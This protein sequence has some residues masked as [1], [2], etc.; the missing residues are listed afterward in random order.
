MK[1]KQLT[2]IALLISF[3]LVSSIFIGISM[4]SNTV[5][6]R[7]NYRPSPTPTASSSGSV[8]F[9]NAF[10]N[11]FSG[12][13]TTGSVST[14]LNSAI[15]SNTIKAVGPESYW[16]KSLAGSYSDLFF[17]GYV[18]VASLPSN[19]QNTLLLK[20][21]DSSFA[22]IVAGG[23]QV[24]GGNSYW[25]L[26]TNGN[27]YTA[28]T[29]SNVQTNHWYF[30]EIEYNTAGTAKMWVDGSLLYTALGES[31]TN[32]PSILQGG[33][34]FSGTPAGF[35]S[36]ATGYTAATSFIVDPPLG[37]PSSP[38]PTPTATSTPSPTAT[39]QPTAT[40]TATPSPSPVPTATPSPTPKPSPTPTPTLAPTPTATPAPTPSP[41]PKPTATPSPTPTPTPAPSGSPLW[42]HTSGQN[43]YDSNGK[44]VKL[45]T[46]DIEYGGS[47]HITLSDIQKIKSMGFNAVR[48]HIY[49]QVLQPNGPTSVNTAA[50]TSTGNVEP[51]GIGLDSIVNWC[52]Q[53]G[54]YI[55]L[56]P[57]WSS[58]WAPPSWVPTTSYGQTTGD[59]GR[60]VNLLGDT[61]VQS[62][63]NYLYNWMAQHYSAN[64]NVI[65]ESFNELLTPSNTDGGTPF[66]N[67][68]NGWVSA[69]EQG[70]G[71]NHHLVLVEMLWNTNW[72]YILTAPY[73]AGTHSNIILAT[74]NYDPMTGWIGIDSNVNDWGGSAWMIQKINSM[75]D[76]AHSAGYPW[77]NTEFSKSTDQSNWQSWYTTEMTT[78]KND[79]AAGWTFWCYCSNPNTATGSGAAW[80]INNP[81]IGPQI[82]PY[83]Q[84]Y[85]VQP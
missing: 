16:S 1:Q 66:A 61:T 68:N 43:I 11:G 17:S 75:A 37:S 21:Y 32:R 55:I 40:P 26:R 67:F 24:S 13:W 38:T 33:N 82:L 14:S 6:A 31:L 85:M 60:A 41:T 72:Q 78:F 30:V 84:P 22:N 65:F 58:G 7:P 36:F 10:Q 81:T 80:N 27:Y 69:I 59:S 23:I 19:G 77:M 48:L 52:A 49:W 53:N 46:V 74:H 56:N 76:A 50:F 79:N 20:I 57:Q 64:S 83:L 12:L 45:Y 39:P 70:E 73:I 29:P 5:D 9:Q 42:L 8:V 71:S 18:S 63:V 3:V 35:T 54:M 62:G 25:F 15:G 44:Q 51:A 2:T 28:S 4:Q 34:P 47:Q